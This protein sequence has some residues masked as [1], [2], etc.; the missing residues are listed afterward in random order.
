MEP[1]ASGTEEATRRLIL[2]GIWANEVGDYRFSAELNEEA[3]ALAQNAGARRL[4][5]IVMNNLGVT[6]ESEGDLARATALF[7][8][9]LAIARELGA[10]EE[11]A[12]EGHNLSR[13]FI[14]PGRVDEAAE[15]VKEGLKWA[16]DGENAV[17]LTDGLV[18]AGAVAYRRGST[19]DA[20]RSVGAWEHLGHAVGSDLPGAEEDFLEAMVKE[21]T[22]ELGAERYAKALSEGKAMTLN[23]AVEYALASID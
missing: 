5:G 11:G 14:T 1:A 19:E 2:L 15:A 6:A 4:I 12:V 3:I 10:L 17:S 23:E 21:L 8:E 13:A 9:A 7:E 20:A 18:L 16:R 22:V